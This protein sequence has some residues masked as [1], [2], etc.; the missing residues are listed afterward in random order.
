MGE[1]MSGAIYKD[2]GLD[3]DDV[4]VTLERSK[5]GLLRVIIDSSDAF[6]ID[7]FP[8]GVPK[9]RLQINDHVFETRADGSLQPVAE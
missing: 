5:D 1:A 3:L 4:W 2:E 6:P 8:L 7:L 9:L